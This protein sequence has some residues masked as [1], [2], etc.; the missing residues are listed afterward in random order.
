MIADLPFLLKLWNKGVDIAA[1]VVTSTLSAA[2]VALIAT[3]TWGWKR[4][5][6]LKFEADKQRQQHAIAEDLANKQRADEEVA[7]QSLLR[8][9]LEALLRDFANAG[10]PGSPDHLQDAW[11]AWVTWLKNNKLEY[12]P[13]NRNVLNKWVGHVFRQ[14]NSQQTASQLADRLI[15]DIKSTQLGPRS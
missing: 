4:S 15:G 10:S 6:D 12:L 3:G 5:R 9:E 7:R 2:I 11:D 14:V 8:Q 13:D 1:G